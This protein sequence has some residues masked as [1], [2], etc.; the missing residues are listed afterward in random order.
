MV[1][2]IY[3][4]KN[5]ELSHIIKLSHLI[6]EQGEIR[7]EF[8]K[9]ELNPS[10]WNS[11]GE[12]DQEIRKKLLEIADDFFKDLKIN[13]PVEDI[14]LTGSLA[15]FNWTRNSDLDVH[16]LIDFSKID[17]NKDL[18][19]KGLDGQRFVWNL[20][21]NVVIRSHDV[22][23]YAQD[24]NEPHVASGL[25]SLLHNKWIKEPKLSDP[26]IDYK[27]VDSKF[28]GFVSDIHEI[29]NK[30]SS[31]VTSEDEA[32]GLYDH[33]LKIKTKILKSRKEGLANSGEFSVENLAFKKLRNEGYIEKLIDLISKAYSK[34]YNE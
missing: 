32:R 28:N 13:A 2:W 17:P 4:I 9:K 30:L 31:E 16:V 24:V 12:F 25:F 8:Y 33:T 23:L 5:P 6:F 21:H 27:D 1:L 22:E 20:R 29:Q 19:K 18:V 34:I 14:Q 10:F 11:N 3:N 15:N 26:Q 7:D